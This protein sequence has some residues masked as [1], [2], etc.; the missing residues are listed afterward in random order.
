MLRERKDIILLVVRAVRDITNLTEVYFM[1]KKTPP[2]K[3]IVLSKSKA[4]KPIKIAKS[5]SKIAKPSANLKKTKKTESLA[6]SS[7]AIKAQKSVKVLTDVPDKAAI[8]PSS[9]TQKGKKDLINKDIEEKQEPKKNQ[10][11]VSMV[12]EK[13]DDEVSEKVE[14]IGKIKPVKIERGNIADEKAKWTEL[15]KK[16]GKE[17]ALV[18]KMTESYPSLMPIQHK[19]LGWGYILTNENDRLEVLF[20]NGIRILISNYKS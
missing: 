7:R 14:K 12:E 18:Y 1:A 16:F 20:E 17:K 19:V 15:N 5:S 9:M 6:S 10:T 13:P 8:K 4:A 11:I 3:K 2:K